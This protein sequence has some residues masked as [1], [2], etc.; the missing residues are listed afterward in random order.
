MCPCESTTTT[1]C[2]YDMISPYFVF[3]VDCIEAG[4]EKESLC[5]GLEA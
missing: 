4:W 3:V 2:R 5:T 1:A